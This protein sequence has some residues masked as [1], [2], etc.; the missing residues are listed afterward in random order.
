MIAMLVGA[1]VAMV[2]ALSAL[3]I[4]AGPTLYDR[5]LGVTSACNHGALIAAA[6]A[7]SAG[8]DDWID[9]C[10]AFLAVAMVTNV[11]VLKFFRARTFQTPLTNTGGTG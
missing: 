10:F 6:A 9:I 4:I 1:A 2:L 11:A 7:V 3:R 5:V 8:R